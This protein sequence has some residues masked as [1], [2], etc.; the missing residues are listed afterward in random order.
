MTQNIN[1]ILYDRT[2]SSLQINMLTTY[3]NVNFNK[4][5]ECT[6]FILNTHAIKRLSKA[7]AA[8]VNAIS[9]IARIA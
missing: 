2:L 4:L 6:V 8:L 3:M 7:G 9:D 1:T 5:L